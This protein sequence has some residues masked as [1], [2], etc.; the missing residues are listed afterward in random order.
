MA[1]ELVVLFVL[2]CFLKALSVRRAPS[3]PQP[4]VTLSLT[5]PSRFNPCETITVKG[6]LTRDGQPIPYADVTVY[7]S[8]FGV[9]KP[10][11]SVK[12][13]ERGEFTLTGSLGSPIHFTEYMEVA[14][15]VWAEAK[16]ENMVYRSPVSTATVYVENCMG[17]CPGIFQQISL[18]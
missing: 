1:F 6:S 9:T 15:N 10:I 17:P 16:V 8:A 3:P 11:V 18:S 7:A 5:V 14:V 13:D 4:T 12:T 2:L